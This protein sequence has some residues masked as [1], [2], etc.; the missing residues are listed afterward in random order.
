MDIR[1]ASHA[2]APLISSLNDDVQLIHYQ[3]MPHFFKPP[4]AGAFPAALVTELTPTPAPMGATA[5]FEIDT[6]L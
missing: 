3:A 5:G 4:A 6:R 2:D 1:R